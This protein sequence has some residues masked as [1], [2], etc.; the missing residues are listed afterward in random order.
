MTY[1]ST[2]SG[3]FTSDVPNAMKRYFSYSSSVRSYSRFANI[4]EW[5][6]LLYNELQ[7]GRPIIYAG[8]DGTGAAGH[9]FNLDGYDGT[10]M[11][12]VNWGWGGT[13]NGYYRIDNLHDQYSNYTK[14]HQAVV[15]IKDIYYGPSDI[16]L[17]NLSIGEG[18]AVGTTVGKLTIESEV[19]PENGYD[20]ELKGAYNIFLDAYMPAD[21]YIENDELKSKK[22][23]AYS[24]MDRMQTVY[25]K[26]IN[27]TNRLPYE[28]MFTVSI[29]KGTDVK[30]PEVNDIR[31]YNENHRLHVVVDK[32]CRYIL[33]SLTGQKVGESTLVAG[34]NLLPT[35]ML[36]GYYLLTIVSDNSIFT[37]KVGL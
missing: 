37:K 9:A 13:N 30:L 2:G 10:S 22:V 26:A 20:Y 18:R 4:D 36:K 7:E 16:T 6:S 5:E 24:D 29:L 3:A 33:Y 32:P 23:F 12:H 14:G 34:T 8:N 28:K 11:Y 1:S 25:I 35:P 27:R 19:P 17:S 21:F 15:G 31:V